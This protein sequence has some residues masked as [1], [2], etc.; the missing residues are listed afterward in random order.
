MSKSV[1]GPALHVALADIP[2][3]SLVPAKY[4]AGGSL[5]AKIA[6]GLD[7]SLMVA[8]RQPGYHS[9]PHR[10]DAEQLNY[11]LDGELYVFVDDDGFL[12][13]TGDIFRIPRNAIHWS[14][15]QGTR[16]CVLLESHTPPLIGD[17]DV[18]DTAVALIGRDEDR[19]QIVAV[20]SAWP[21]GV[22]QGVVERRVVATATA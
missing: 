2:E 10:H 11:V 18:T 19:T 4:L 12:A 21:E 22:D 14:W 6:Y 5:G 7:S 15:M 1:P 8:V 16:P 13:K 17:P 20:P 9:R 3:T